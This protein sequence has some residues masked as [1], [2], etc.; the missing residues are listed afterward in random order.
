MRTSRVRHVGDV[1]TERSGTSGGAWAHGRA[2]ADAGAGGADAPP[3][4]AGPAPTAGPEGHAGIG[5]AHPSLASG[6]CPAASARRH[7][8][9]I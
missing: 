4:G 2:G 6:G 5:S 1:F 8:A 9:A 3:S 7:M